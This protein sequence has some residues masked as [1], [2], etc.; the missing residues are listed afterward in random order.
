VVELEK[1]FF[2][3]TLHTIFL[4]VFAWEFSLAS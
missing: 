1:S 4:D 3:S 2:F